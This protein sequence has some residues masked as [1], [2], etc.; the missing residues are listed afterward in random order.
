MSGVLQELEEDTSL[1]AR[2]GMVKLNAL[3]MLVSMI[4][5]AT[6]LVTQKTV[7][8]CG[9]FT[10]LVLCFAIAALTLSVI[11]RKH[12]AHVTRT[13]VR[14]GLTVGVFVFA[15]YALQT[16]GLQ[17]TTSSKAGFI[18]GLYVP[19]VPLLA[20]VLLRQRPSRGAVIGVFLSIIGLALL[21]INS[22]FTL[23]FGPGEWLVLGCAF[24]FALQ[25][26]YTSKYVVH[27]DAINLTIIQ[28]AVTSLLSLFMIPVTREHVVMP[29]AIAWIAFLFMGIG[30]MAFTFFAINWAQQRVSSTRAALIY[31]LEPAWAGLFGVLAGQVLSLPA[32]FGCSCIFLGMIAG[33]LRLPGRIR[34]IR[35]P[36]PQSP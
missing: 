4:W 11:F 25:I 6:F 20:F 33:N 14:M 2:R 32:W 10:Y 16:C 3:L 27:V 12:L 30:D 35:G 26:V 21:S 15:G 19:L 28:L 22:S 24:A 36:D 8:L 9:P 31:A 18:T 5:G 34:Q 23:A 13:E 7:A 17:Y 1:P 29:P